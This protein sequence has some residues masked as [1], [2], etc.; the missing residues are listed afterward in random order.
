MLK[1]MARRPVPEMGTYLKYGFVIMEHQYQLCPRCG[2]AL[3][4]GPDYQPER[5]GQCGQSIDFEGTKWK[6][7][8]QLGYLERRDG[9]EPIE[10]RVCGS[11]MESNHGL[12]A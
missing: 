10:D 6:E 12:P 2:N 8:R 4:A 3:N 7:D 1:I 9:D 5:C 11:Y